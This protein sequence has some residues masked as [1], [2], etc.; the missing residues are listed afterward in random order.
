M[1]TSGCRVDILAWFPSNQQRLLFQYGLTLN[2]LTS[3]SHY[4]IDILHGTSP[5]SRYG[6]L[7]ATSLFTNPRSAC[8]MYYFLCVLITW[9][10]Y[11]CEQSA[12]ASFWKYMME[13]RLSQASYIF[14]QYII[15]GN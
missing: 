14:T 2:R 1:R 13:N 9:S 12:S 11:C 5:G 6:L 10:H 15:W 4:S 7:T 3:A 8:K